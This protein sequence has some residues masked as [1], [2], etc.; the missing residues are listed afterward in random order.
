MNV[1]KYIQKHLVFFILGG[2]VSGFLIGLFVNTQPLRVSVNW[3]SF[4]LVY[5]MMVTLNFKSL[6]ARGNVKLQLVTQLVN[7]GYLP[8]LA[9]VFGVVFFP[10][11]E[12]MSYRLGILLI[13]LLPTSGMTVSWTVMAKGNVQEAIRMIVI[14]LMLGGLLTPLMINLYLGTTIALSFTQI[15]AQIVMIVFIP[16]LLGFLT[17]WVLKKRYG[18][19]TFHQQIKANFPP[20]STLSVILLIALVMS[21]RAPM[22]ARNPGVLIELLVPITLGYG[23]MLISL[24]LL[25]KAL[26]PYA[27]HI[28]FMN[29]TMIRSLSV[30]LAIALTVFEDAGVEVSLVIALAYIVQVQMAASYVKWSQKRFKEAASSLG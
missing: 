25:G 28:A 9:Y 26:F 27:D 19:A 3:L 5:P 14:G 30:A 20:F 22:L 13:A 17:Q 18:E 8:L 16:M 21:L 1:L 7:F 11:P 6:L 4:F 23:V 2:M 15:L 10:H 12:Q 24:H 29:G